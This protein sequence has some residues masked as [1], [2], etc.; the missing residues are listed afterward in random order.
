VVTPTRRAVVTATTPVSPP[1]VA[2]TPATSAPAPTPARPRISHPRV[3]RAPTAHHA[4]P[5]TTTF[6]F[7]LA[8]PRDLLLLPAKALRAGESDRRDGALL[9]LTSVAMALLAVASLALLRRLK[10]L[11]LR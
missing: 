9:L 1:A 4:A 7:P 5:T 6:S 8:F 3:H 11:E 10:R 2:S